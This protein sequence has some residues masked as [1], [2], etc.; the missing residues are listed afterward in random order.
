MAYR[1]YGAFPVKR[2]ICL[3]TLPY[4]DCGTAFTAAAVEGWVDDRAFPVKRE[5]CLFTL[6]YSDCGTAFT[7]AAVEGWVDDP[8]GA[9]RQ[10]RTSCRVLV[11]GGSARPE[12]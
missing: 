9:C 8:R 2:E 7:A 12:P 4:S 1:L 11:F 10:A 3:F 5:I 6:P